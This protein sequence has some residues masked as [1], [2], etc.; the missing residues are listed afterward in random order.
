[1]DRKR[2]II[3]SISVLL[4][5]FFGT[6]SSQQLN[7]GS[8]NTDA[9]MSVIVGFLL[10]S[11]QQN[12]AAF[13][14]GEAVNFQVPG[15]NLDAVTECG[16]SQELP[17]GLT[18][19]VNGDQTGCEIV[20]SSTQSFPET[21]ITIVA[22]DDSGNDVS[23]SVLISVELATEISGLVTY[24]RVP[25]NVATGLDFANARQ[26]PVRGATVELLDSVGNI[27]QTTS[28]GNDGR[29][30]FDVAS[31][32]LRRVR[33]KAE[34]IQVS[35]TAAN[36]NVVIVDNTSSGALYSL[37]E[38]Q[39]STVTANPIRNLNA[40][41]GWSIAVNRYTGTRA[42]AP[43]AIL[44]SIYEAMT[45]VIAVDPDVVFPPLVA[46][47]SINN[48]ISAPLQGETT[49]QARAAGRIGTSF[50]IPSSFA[51][52]DSNAGEL[53]LV[54]AIDSDTDEFD[55]HIVIHEWGHYF[56]D[57]LSRSDSIGGSHGG[58]NLLDLRLAFSEGFG[59]AISAIATDDPIYAD[60]FTFF[61]LGFTFSFD[62]EEND[63]ENPGWYSEASVQS[64]LYDLYDTDNDGSDDLSVG[65]K[66]IYDVMTGSGHAETDAFTSIFSFSSSFLDSQGFSV[67]N[68]FE[69]LLE[70]QSIETFVLDE[71]GSP[72]ERN[73]GGLSISD[74]RD[75]YG[76]VSLT[77]NTP[78]LTFADLTVDIV[79]TT[80]DFIE[81][82]GQTNKLFN[83]AFVEIDIPVA[84]DHI[85]AI[86]EDTF[87]TDY[88]S[89]VPT[90]FVY[91]NGEFL[92]GA[93]SVTDTSV[94][95]SIT[96]SE[97]GTHVIEVFDNNIE[98]DVGFTGTAC[99][100]VG[101]VAP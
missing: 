88:D 53:F 72:F 61:N 12:F 48:S 26:E 67:S 40:S 22:S 90:A 63:V 50:Y 71:F 43:F 2:I 89:T 45:D 79:C 17:L 96:L 58:G 69:D 65:L 46:N 74:F 78:N 57:R 21:L 93:S 10:D 51:L 55:Q 5:F 23:S 8:G 16:A 77:E 13:S 34:A 6:A 38:A 24:D 31:N 1:M 39:A 59:N 86:I 29:Y 41:S 60:S 14:S 100:R 19:Q 47:W 18:L 37:T 80:T 85:V 87:S 101:V 82:D 56:E 76:T 66:P 49:D 81:E 42:A 27:L 36:Y 83:S 32:E 11:E 68:A 15:I 4:F 99:F 54:G 73:F 92:G 94:A 75:V 70:D 84:G 3:S 20:G 52:F 64:L 25:I 98:S 62:I 33:I 7:N 97:P 95:F 91:K 35:A 30:A 28:T 9:A 44:D